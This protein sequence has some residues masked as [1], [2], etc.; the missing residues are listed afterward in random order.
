MSE[1]VVAGVLIHLMFAAPG[2][3]INPPSGPRLVAN[4]LKGEPSRFEFESKHM[5]TTFRIVLYATDK[6]V[7]KKAADAAFTR[8]AQLDATM[9]DYKK[10]SELTLL[11][12]AFATDVGDPVAVGDDLFFVLQ[13]ADELS[14]KS[15]GAF[16]VTVGPVVQLW[17]LARRTQQF[18][19][20]KELA[21]ARAKVGYQKVKLDTT[22]KTVRLT[23]PGMQLDLGGIAK[24]YAADEALK[25]LREKFGIT[26]A[27]VAAYG[28]ITCGDPPPGEQ[29]WKVDI[30]PIAKSQKPRTLKLANAAVST[31]GDLEQFVEIAGVRYSHVLDPKTG[32]GLTGRRS[33]TV[34]APNGIT[35]DS[36]TKA[37][38][39]LPPEQG[40]KLVD[41]TP[42]AATSIVVLGQNN[43][44][45]VT[46][47]K[48]FPD[49]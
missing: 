27:L 12:K 16:D 47:S 44:P 34:I 39:V 36:M 40:L 49:E 29:A 3:E 46:A 19:D 43:K 21:A 45:V 25:L 41:A 31:S 7:A 24:G 2:G 28:D 15:D 9:S 8:V 18:P 4:V 30:A 32:V 38:S 6:A 48:R 33:V 5:G 35:A 1:F 10:D 42:G 14:K 11:C 26:Q 13:K 17:R 23:I 20:A 37:V 22:K